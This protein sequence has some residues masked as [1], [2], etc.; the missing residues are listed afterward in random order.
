VAHS[1]PTAIA[2]DAPASPWEPAGRGAL[3][4]PQTDGTDGMYVLRLRRADSAS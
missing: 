4:L 2:L 3:L 1:H